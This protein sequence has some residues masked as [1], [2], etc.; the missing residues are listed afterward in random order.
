MVTLL[1]NKVITVLLLQDLLQDSMAHLV[2][3]NV[4]PWLH[5]KFGD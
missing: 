1:L 4:L 5:D 3:S 2:S